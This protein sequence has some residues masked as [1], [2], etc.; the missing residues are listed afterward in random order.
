MLTLPLLAHGI[1][2]LTDARYFA[3]WHPDYLCFPV[4]PGGITADYFTAIREWVEG[5]VCV[6]ELSTDNDAAALQEVLQIPGLTHL[7]LD[8]GMATPTV[9]GQPLEY[10]TRLPVAGYQA[11]T[12]VAERLA[13]LTGPVVLDFTDGGIT[14]SDLVEGHPVSTDSLKELIGDRKVYVRIDLMPDE[15]GKARDTVYGLALKGSSEEKVGYKSFED[16]EDML[17]ALEL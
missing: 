3:A 2:H 7:M 1:T 17:E 11:A 13:E 4:G 8:Y 6:A 5:P 10:I 12:D 9:V 16:I 15:A 14:W